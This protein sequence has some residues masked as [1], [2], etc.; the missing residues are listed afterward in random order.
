[1]ATSPIGTAERMAHRFHRCPPF[2]HQNLGRPCGTWNPC[3]FNPALK[4]RAIVIASPGDGQTRVRPSSGRAG[5]S[6]PGPAMRW[7]PAFCPGPCVWP[8]LAVSHHADGQRGRDGALRRPLARAFVSPAGR[9]LKN[10]AGQKRESASGDIAAQ[11]PYQSAVRRGIFVEPKT[12]I[13]FSPV[14]AA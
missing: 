9:L 14:G 2:R 1:M 8:D 12:K 11:C 4:C 6:G 3:G 7:P 13:I 5:Q 10:S